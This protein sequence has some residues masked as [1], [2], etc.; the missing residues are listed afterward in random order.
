MDVGFVVIIKLVVAV[1]VVA[2]WLGF[3]TVGVASTVK[4]SVGDGA[5][6]GVKNAGN[7]LAGSLVGGEVVE[8]VGLG[9]N[10][11]T[12]YISVLQLRKLTHRLLQV[13]HLMALEGLDLLLRVVL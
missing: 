7:A 13:G 11:A 2:G 6:V 3:G 9:C 5:S 1:D 12:H 4:G 10:K 8:E